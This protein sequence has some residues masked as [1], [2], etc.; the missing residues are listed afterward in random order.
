MLML[1]YYVVLVHV[2]FFSHLDNG[3][4][5]HL[6]S[7]KQ[8]KKM[9][10]HIIRHVG[11]QEMCPSVTSQAEVKR[12]VTGCDSLSLS[13]TSSGTRNLAHT[14]EQRNEDENVESKRF[15]QYTHC[16]NKCSTI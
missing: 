4:L 16:N 1:V 2:T 12:Y 13:T 9:G 10:Y 6:T 8:T 3:A 7:I 14:S 11:L 5:K 15:L